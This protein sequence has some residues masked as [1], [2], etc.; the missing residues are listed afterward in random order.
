MTVADHEVA[1]EADSPESDSSVGESMIVAA[2][3]RDIQPSTAFAL[4]DEKTCLRPSSGVTLVH[5]GK[6]PRSQ[7]AP[8]SSDPANKSGMSS[9]CAMTNGHLS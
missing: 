3:G 7:H 4:A 9:G 8:S 5:L 1:A 2:A 6:V